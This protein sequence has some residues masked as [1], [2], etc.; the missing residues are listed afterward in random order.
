M[1]SFDFVHSESILL[2]HL[3]NG[4]GKNA[5]GIGVKIPQPD[6]GRCEEL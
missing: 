4:V 3:T 6:E 5:L 2:F 1:Y